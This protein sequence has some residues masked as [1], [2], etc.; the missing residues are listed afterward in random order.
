MKAILSK[1]VEEEINDYVVC[2]SNTAIPYWN[3]RTITIR[4]FGIPVYRLRHNTSNRER[5][6]DAKRASYPQKK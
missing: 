3:S 1:E 2:T 6:R 5:E 4:L